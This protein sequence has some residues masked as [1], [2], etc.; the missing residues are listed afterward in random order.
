MTPDQ[1]NGLF[2]VAGSVAIWKNSYTLAKDRK[3]HGVHPVAMSFFVVWSIWNLF[4]YP[5]LDQWWSF[6]GGVAMLAALGVWISQMIYWR[7]R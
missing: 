1:I 7:T 3:V 6:A 2:E 5:S 4:Y